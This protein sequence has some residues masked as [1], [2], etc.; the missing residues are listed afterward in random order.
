MFVFF[1]SSLLQMTWRSIYS[2]RSSIKLFLLQKALLHSK[3]STK[4]QVH[5]RIRDIMFVDCFLYL[6]QIEPTLA[7]H[8]HHCIFILNIVIII[9]DKK[10]GMSGM[11]DGR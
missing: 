4:R 7:L 5:H 1:S 9:L 3:G 11:V 2:P 10:E 8:Q 6:T